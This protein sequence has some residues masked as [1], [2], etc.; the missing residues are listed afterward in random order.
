[1]AENDATGRGDDL[2]NEAALGN[3]AGQSEMRAGSFISE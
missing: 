3:Q 2:Q 1:M